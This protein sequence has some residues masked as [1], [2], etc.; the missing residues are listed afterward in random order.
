MNLRLTNGG[1]SV[2][3]QLSEQQAK[4]MATLKRIALTGLIVSWLLMPELL[5]HKA[6]FILHILYEGGSYLLEEILIHSFGMRKYYAQLTVFY[7]SWSIALLLI[8]RMW[9]RL[10]VL[11]HRTRD[12]LQSYLQHLKSQASAIWHRLTASQKIA[13]LLFQFG[14]AAACF[15]LMLS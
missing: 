13:V 2:K 3:P 11:A 9:R 4:N 1:L 7:F 12:W 5:W 15:M 6:A 10:P 8:Y 14:T